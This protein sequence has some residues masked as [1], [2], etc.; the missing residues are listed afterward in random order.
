MKAVFDQGFGII[1]QPAQFTDIVPKLV[2][3]RPIPLGVVTQT[4]VNDAAPHNHRVVVYG[5]AEREKVGNI[6]VPGRLF[7][8][9]AVPVMPRQPVAVLFFR[10]HFQPRAHRDDAA[11]FFHLA[12]DFLNPVGGGNIVGIG[13]CNI[14]P[15]PRLCQFVQPDV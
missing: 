2:I 10:Q 8:N 9:F 11:V 6:F 13:A 5:V 3:F 1:S 12:H 4:A 14:F 7:P 15:P